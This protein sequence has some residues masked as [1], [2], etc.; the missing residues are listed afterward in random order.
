MQAN[1]KIIPIIFTVVSGSLYNITPTSTPTT[2]VITANITMDFDSVSYFKEKAQTIVAKVYTITPEIKSSLLFCMVHSL[3]KIS[4]A[5][6]RKATTTIK[7]RNNNF[8]YLFF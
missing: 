4:P 3:N 7:A 6:S 2:R 1:P 5:I 8:I